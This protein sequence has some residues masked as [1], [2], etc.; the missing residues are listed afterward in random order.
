MFRRIRNFSAPHSL[1]SLRCSTSLH[2]RLRLGS[3]NKRVSGSLRCTRSPKFSP[4]AKTSDTRQPLSEIEKGQTE[5][6]IHLP[7][8]SSFSLTFLLSEIITS[9][10]F[11]F[12]LSINSI[13]SLQRP[14][15]YITLS[16]NAT[17]VFIC[18]SLL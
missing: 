7:G 2:S 17:I 18:V 10:L 5:I 3:F 8:K 11:Q 12:L 14:Q 1:R 13:I 16:P 9:V 4:M 6:Y 15:G